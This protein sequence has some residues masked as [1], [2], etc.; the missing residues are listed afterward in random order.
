LSEVSYPRLKSILESL[1]FVSN[2]PLTHEEL[3][4]IIGVEAELI[5]RALD[6]LM[7]EYENKGLQIAKVAGGWQM[8]TRVENAEFV[9]KL[10]SSP[11][12]T[13]LSPAAMETLAIIAYKQPV[14]RL[15]VEGIRGVASDGVVKTLLDK[16]M[17]KEVGRSDAVGRPF[18]YG[19]TIEFLRHF[20]LKD[21]GD[22][23]VL[24]PGA[25]EQINAFRGGEVLPPE[26]EDKQMELK[27]RA[28][29]EEV[30]E[31]SSEQS[32]N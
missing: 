27:E 31:G 24:P 12:V 25:M 10:L 2:K 26:V 28:E 20:G 11:I 6:E 32:A 30:L 8:S 1:L 5:S 16:R 19:T 13:T 29:N 18:L 23:P 15:E 9:D 7:V 4:P 17:I 3:A 22:L 14:T 21:L